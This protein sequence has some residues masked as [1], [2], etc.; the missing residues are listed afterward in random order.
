MAAPNAGI[1][2]NGLFGPGSQQVMVTGPRDTLAKLKHAIDGQGHVVSSKS[3]STQ[4]ALPK[5]CYG[6]LQDTGDYPSDFSLNKLLN[7]DYEALVGVTRKQH[8]DELPSDAELDLDPPPF[9]R[10][11]IITQLGFLRA[12]ALYFHNV[13]ADSEDASDERVYELGILTSN[14]G[15]GFYTPTYT[16]QVYKTRTDAES[17]HTLW[18][19]RPCIWTPHPFNITDGAYEEGFQGIGA[20]EN[21]VVSSSGGSGGNDDNDGG[22][23]QELDVSQPSPAAPRPLGKR[24]P[25]QKK[26]ASDDDDDDDMMI[27]TGPRLKRKATDPEP[28]Y[29]GELESE[30]DLPPPTKPRSR[31]RARKT[32]TSDA[33]DEKSPKK[34]EVKKKRNVPKRRLSAAP[35]DLIDQTPDQILDADPDFILQDVLLRVT[36]HY[37]NGQILAR[38]NATL[39]RDGRQPIGDVNNVARRIVVALKLLASKSGRDYEELKNEV[40]RSRLKNGVITPNVNDPKI[41]ELTTDEDAPC[42][43]DEE[44]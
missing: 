28:E 36:P 35:A 30:N 23:E 26:P 27:P 21:D 22:D 34:G 7:G 43:T 44:V 29:E 12:V 41:E 11:N 42:V 10:I 31:K 6:H 2:I 40:R 32:S 39:V 13:M 25:R 14:A 37:T 24:K 38:M 18:L 15:Y 17:T 1:T 8:F 16:A 9:N 20:A 4:F 33:G 5:I 3:Y 19:Y